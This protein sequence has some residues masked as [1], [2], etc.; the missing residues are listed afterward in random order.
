MGSFLKII[1]INKYN[2]FLI[3][4]STADGVGFRQVCAGGVSGV[5]SCSGDSGGPLKLPGPVGN[6]FS[7]VQHG[8]VS[9]GPK[10][11]G[12]PGTPAVYTRVAYYMDWILNQLKSQ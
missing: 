8:I 12:T 3:Y 5:D 10:N 7:Y 2:Y 9:Y 6:S 4:R 1:P 11:C